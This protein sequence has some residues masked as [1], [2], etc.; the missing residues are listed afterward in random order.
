MIDLLILTEFAN[1]QG[2]T[3]HIAF[4]AMILMYS[5]VRRPKRKRKNTVFS[6]G[7]HSFNRLWNEFEDGNKSSFSFLFC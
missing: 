2:A 4:L 6:F 5:T 7:F 3:G 1:V